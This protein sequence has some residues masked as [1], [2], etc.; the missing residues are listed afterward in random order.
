MANETET[1]TAPEPAKQPKATP[2]RTSAIVLAL[3]ITLIVLMSYHYTGSIV[4]EALA[5]LGSG[6]ASEVKDGV[7]QLMTGVVQNMV[8]LT[9]VGGLIGAIVKLCEN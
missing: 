9:A 6:E 4:S 1:T 3:F 5:L 7:I 2:F 8:A